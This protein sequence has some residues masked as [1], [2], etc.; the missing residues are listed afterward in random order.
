MTTNQTE[1]ESQQE[2]VKLQISGL[3]EATKSIT[4]DR[5]QDPNHKRKRSRRK[6]DKSKEEA[7]TA[8]W[9][10]Y[11][12]KWEESINSNGDIKKIKT[13]QQEKREKKLAELDEE[14]KR[15]FGDKFKNS[16]Q[17]PNE[18]NDNIIRIYGQ[19]INGVSRYTNYNEWEIILENLNKQQ[20]DIACLSEINLDLNKADI[21]YK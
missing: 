9:W 21:K 10:H 17:W 4:I 8:R 7:R 11:V 19:N 6:K 14:K 13:I 20:I 1:S 3:E 12:R 18:T 5:W 2:W 16:K 15:W